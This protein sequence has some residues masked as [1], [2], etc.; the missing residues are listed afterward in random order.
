MSRIPGARTHDYHYEN[1]KSSR[2]HLSP[3]ATITMPSEPDIDSGLDALRGW[4]ESAQRHEAHL[5]S[6]LHDAQAEV[7]MIKSRFAEFEAQKHPIGRIPNELL[8]YIFTLFVQDLDQDDAEGEHKLCHWRPVVL[9]HVSHLWRTLALS[10][11]CLWSRIVLLK[12]SPVS[13]VDHFTTHAGV[14]PID[15]VGS[16]VDDGHLIRHAT[17]ITPGVSSPME[18][19]CNCYVSSLLD[20][21]SPPISLRTY[22][23]LPPVDPKTLL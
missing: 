14:S 21:Y 13:A 2:D 20:G 22:H 19:C 3:S 4:L 17:L 1:R 10:T 9:S 15:I 11:S 16:G 7:N 23:L 18:D 6:L 8:I 12:N 5:L